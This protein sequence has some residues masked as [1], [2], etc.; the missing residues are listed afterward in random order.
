MAALNCTTL[1]GAVEAVAESVGACVGAAETVALADAEDVREA[2]AEPVAMD[3]AV[4]ETVAVAE[5][6]L[7]MHSL[8]PMRE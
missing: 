8:E 6:E 7:S 5:L 1:K 4:A 2:V 3:E